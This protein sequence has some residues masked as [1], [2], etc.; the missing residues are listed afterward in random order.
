MG[1]SFTRFRD[2][3]FWTRDSKLE[4][5]LHLLVREIDALSNPPNW[6]PQVREHWL[7]QSTIGFQG[8]V[9]AKLDDFAT[10]E[11]RTRV[12]LELAHKT[13]ERLEQFGETVPKEF[14]NMLETG[15]KGSVWKN[16]VPAI[17]FLRVSQAFKDLLQGRLQTDA[18]T[19][20]ML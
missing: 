4:V 1:S 11:D 8:C 9:S 14:L 3:G 12:L 15:G 6:L 5:W 7:I 16:D 20:P 10:D 17:D 18:S 13:R 2:R 19:S